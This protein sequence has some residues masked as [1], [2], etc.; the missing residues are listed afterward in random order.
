MG[1]NTEVID[2]SCTDIDE[3]NG[4]VLPLLDAGDRLDRNQATS[5]DKPLHLPPLAPSVA[6]TRGRKAETVPRSS[7]PLTQPAGAWAF[8]GGSGQVV[9]AVAQRLPDDDLPVWQAQATLGWVHHSA[10]AARQCP[11]PEPVRLWEGELRR[12]FSA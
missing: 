11:E 4:A 8:V 12:S 2:I 9:V 5:N 3:D 7:A 1:I 10:R 6:P